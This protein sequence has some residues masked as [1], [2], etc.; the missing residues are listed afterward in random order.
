MTLSV[1]LGT[2][3]TDAKKPIR[4][5]LRH[6][7]TEQR[8]DTGKLRLLTKKTYHSLNTGLGFA[9]LLIDDRLL[10]VAVASSDRV[11]DAHCLGFHG[12]IN[13]FY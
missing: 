13:L 10:R 4:R 11:R 8:S 7:A 3:R 1:E 9:R 12:Q 2:D 6:T 5:S